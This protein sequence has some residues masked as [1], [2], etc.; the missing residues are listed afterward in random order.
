MS[1]TYIFVLG[2]IVT[3]IAVTGLI[4]V[5]LSEAADPRHSRADDLTDWERSAVGDQR[6][7][8]ERG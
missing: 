2:A 3:A 5:G 1:P 7:E 8:N 6:R 4:L